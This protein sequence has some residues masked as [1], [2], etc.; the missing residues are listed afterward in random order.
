VTI[1]RA[2]ESGL[3]VRVLAAAHDC[4]GFAATSGHTGGDLRWAVDTASSLSA[5]ASSAAPQPTDDIEAE[6]WDLD[7]AAALPGEEALTTGLIARANVEWVEAGTTIELLIGA[8][9]WLA[10][11]R[12]HRFWAFGTGNEARL[13][14][15]RGFAG[16]EHLLDGLGDDGSITAGASGSD[17]GVL[18][19]PPDSATAV[20][21]ALVDE[22]HGQASIGSERIG[23][24]WSVFD[25]PVRVDG[26]AGGS[27]D[28]AGFPVA[29][30]ELS[31]DGIWMGN[32]SGP[33]TFRR[34]SFREPPSEM[35]TN[36]VVP[37]G[38]EHPLPARAAV[39]RRCRVIRASHDQWVLEV[40]LAIRRNKAGLERRWVR[41]HPQ[42]LL[43]ACSAR[44]GAQRVTPTGPI[45]AGL[46][47]EGLISS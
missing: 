34:A 43:A 41:V 13:V 11:R 47:F 25:E 2:L 17:L 18:V 44:L 27:F 35:A 8:E 12:R 42:A 31:V 14:A 22:F 36:L 40:D 39:A 21:S 23:H 9:G 26:L 7:A 5:R 15:Q 46:V 24:G 29:V 38:A 16:W 6:R 10:A 3:A 4:A 30:R 1:D 28:D 37:S 33:G 19:F 20:V 45:V 32:L